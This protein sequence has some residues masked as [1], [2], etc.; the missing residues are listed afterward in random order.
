[1]KK[2]FSKITNNRKSEY[3]IETNIYLQNGKKCVV[4][5][6]LSEASTCHMNKVYAYYENNKDCGLLCESK[7]LSDGNI[8]FKFVEGQTLFT[9]LLAALRENDREQLLMVVD[10]YKAV[11]AKMFF[12]DSYEELIAKKVS[13]ANIDLTFDNIIVKDDNYTIIDYE[14]ILDDVEVAFVV[15]R[16]VYAII[17]KYGSFVE[18]IMKTD[19][20]Y[21]LFLLDVDRID[22]YIQKNI[23]FNEYVYGKLESYDNSLKNYEKD[24]IIIDRNTHELK[25]YAQIYTRK[26]S[27][28]SEKESVKLPVTKDRTSIKYV[29]GIEEDAQQ[30]RIDPLNCSC[31]CENINFV[32]IGRNLEKKVEK[33]NH[34]AFDLGNNNLL[35][36]AEDPQ[37]IID[38][39]ELDGAD[40]LVCEFEVCRNSDIIIKKLNSYIRT[41]EEENQM[42][43]KREIKMA[44][45]INLQNANI[46]TLEH[47]KEI[48]K[49]MGRQLQKRLNEVMADNK[50]MKIKNIQ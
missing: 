12:A 33:F 34:N 48:F 41:K 44:N 17:V 39:K 3:Q 1:M 43:L 30:I 35:F 50:I 14:W 46:Q 25:L 16:A 10:S 22:E 4:K 18:K 27:D 5:R 2:V 11:V 47:D 28:Y 20:L 31:I 13:N 36:G 49:E 15:F 37:I 32:G 26:T 38:V 24:A 7:K 9:K 8:E 40:K 42:L 21:R 29:V 45:Q 19:E 23:E 6:A